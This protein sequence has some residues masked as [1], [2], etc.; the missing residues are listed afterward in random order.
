[1]SGQK[2]SASQST[3]T[4][5]PSGT[6]PASATSGNITVLIHSLNDDNASG[7]PLASGF[8]NVIYTGASNFHPVRVSYSTTFTGTNVTVTQDET[9]LPS[10]GAIFELEEAGV[11]GAASAA[12]TVS[13]TA[14]GE[15]TGPPVKYVSQGAAVAGT[16]SITTA[17]YGTGWAEGDLG[18][19]VVASNHAT[20][21]ATEPTVAGFT[22]IGTLNGGGG[23]QGAGTGN[24][25]LTFFTRE[26]QA[27]DD[28]TPAIDLSGGNVMIA[29]ITILRKP[30]SYTWATA[31][32]AFG[33]ETTAGTGWSE[34]MTT[35]PV[36][37]AADV[38]ILGCAVR[39]TSTTSAE[40]ITATGATF[41]TSAERIDSASETGNDISLHVWTVDVL[42]GPS[43]AAPTC[44]ATH[45]TS[46]TGVMGVLRVRASVSGVT[47]AASAAL[48]ISATAA[49]VP[50]TPGVAA[51]PLAL[52][53]TASG[54]PTTFG[55]AAAALSITATASGASVE[56]GQAA[57]T[58]AVTA[59]ASGVARPVGQAAA[60]LALTATAQ[61]VDRAL[62]LAT[63]TL[64]IVGTAAGTPVVQGSA[65]AALVMTATA[66]GSVGGAPVTG[67]ASAALS[68]TASASGKR[69][70]VGVAA[71]SLTVT[72]TADGVDR[73]V[74]TAA[75]TLGFVATAAGVDRSLGVATATLVVTATASG[76]A[77]TPPV[78]GVATAVIGVTATVVGQHRVVGVAVA[79]IS[80]TG[81]A[82]GVNLSI[83]TPPERTF[84]VPAEDRVTVV[85]AES[86][87]FV[88]P[89][90]SRTMEA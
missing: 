24:R 34:S 25:R 6:M 52:T 7:V 65:S 83:V 17:A 13:A 74:G 8:T 84:V 32:A 54:K 11:S 47:G 59:T 63:S 56:R 72:S 66:A 70:I 27:G 44:T 18:V 39:D 85:P 82:I 81:V 64:S 4:P 21:E 45:S 43:S 22:N 26:L 60:T 1:V 67:A 69:T 31:V 87:T 58:L 76:S 68:V 10:V 75:A 50:T 40:G 37:D 41:G 36:L 23:S 49:G 5:T 29:A 33:A 73:A 79:T 61:G 2:A 88:V 80:A 35:N 15:I 9:S 28:T 51:A 12:L 71:S 78:T 3:G 57:A 90:Q 62:G 55:A 20:T 77:D 86:R 46:E 16:T 30:P 14:A 89:A 53:A 48:S 19:C 38:A 42:T